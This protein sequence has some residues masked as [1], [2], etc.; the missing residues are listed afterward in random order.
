MRLLADQ[1]VYAVTTNLLRELGH[2]VVTAADI[3]LSQSSDIDLLLA[4]IQDKRILLTRDRDFGGLMFVRA[5]RGGVIYLRIL[6]STVSLVHVELV[7]VLETYDEQALLN[8]L[9][10]VEPSGHRIRRNAP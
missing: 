8:A 6:P 10:V 5:I 7:R 2:D 4:A 9:V 1:D 3:G